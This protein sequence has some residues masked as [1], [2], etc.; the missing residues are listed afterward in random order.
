L[1]KGRH[2]CRFIFRVVILSGPVYVRLRLEKARKNPFPVAWPGRRF[3]SAAVAIG[4]GFMTVQRS[5]ETFGV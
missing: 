5:I 2:P 4:P 3:I 1:L